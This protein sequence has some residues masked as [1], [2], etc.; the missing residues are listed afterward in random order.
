[1]RI[2]IGKPSDTSKLNVALLSRRRV[3]RWH[4]YQHPRRMLRGHLECEI[5]TGSP[6]MPRLR[7]HCLHLAARFFERANG[8]ARRMRE[9][10]SVLHDIHRLTQTPHVII[11]D[12][13]ALA[14]DDTVA[15]IRFFKRMAE[16]RRAGL[17]VR[18]ADGSMGP[19]QRRGRSDRALEH[20]WLAA[21][22]D[23]HL[24]VGVPR[25]PS[26]VGPATAVIPRLPVTDRVLGALLARWS[27]QHLL[28]L[29]YTDCYRRMHKRDHGYTV[30]TWMPAARVDYVFADAAVA[31]RL[32]GCDV[33]GSHAFSDR[34]LQPVA[35]SAGSRAYT[36]PPCPV[37]PAVLTPS[38]AA[39]GLR[40][41]TFPVRLATA[42]FG[43]SATRS[44][45]QRPSA[46]A[47][48]CG[49]SR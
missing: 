31:P 13:N 39:P 37:S 48:R 43:S 8:E 20:G 16:L 15:A 6:V 29:G 2:L 4:N 44:R 5:E 10:R 11:G 49:T 12:F 18:G 19:V 34:R 21:G 33:I 41:S 40:P 23:P 42:V 35:G 26:I 1:M 22:I 46:T 38:S 28:D 25:L 45:R 9:M 27:V 3:L 47:R 36:R 17:V 24:D 30:A 32:Q 14:P 7:I